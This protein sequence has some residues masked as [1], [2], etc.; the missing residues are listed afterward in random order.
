MTIDFSTRLESG[1]NEVFPNMIVQKCVFHAIQLLTRGLKKEFTKIKKEHLLDHIDEWISLRRRTFSLEKSEQTTDVSPFKFYDVELAWEIYAQLRECLSRNDPRQIERKLQTFF[2]SSQFIKWYGKHVFLSK[3]DDVFSK[4]NLTYSIKGIEYIV[5]QIYKAF[6]AAIR[7]LRKEL[8]DLKSHFNKIKYLVLMNP[9]NME[10]YHRRKLRKY[11]KE[12]PWL[13][14]YRQLL[15]RF[16]YQFR[17]PPDKRSPLSF[18]SR[19]ITDTSHPRLKS[20]VQ[21]L[22][23]NEES[24]FRFQRVPELFPKIKPSKSIKVVNESCNKL[25]NKL[26]RTQCGMRTI[27]NIRMRISNLLKCPII[28]SPN[29]LEKIK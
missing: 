5:P 14:S 23:D 4:R 19:L 21:T 28:I 27:K 11:L 25:L 24:V 12:F 26:Y 17:L 16:Y 15:V 1:V 22:I 6:R 8:E 9:S 13:R 10:L 7:E 2:S 20:A 29:L 18:L 3:Y